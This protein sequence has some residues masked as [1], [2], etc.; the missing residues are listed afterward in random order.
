VPQYA[1]QG[2]Y[3]TADSKPATALL[4]RFSDAAKAN[5]YYAG[6]QA[7]MSACGDGGDLSVK[8]LWS[9]DTAAASVRR[10]AGDEAESYV[11]VSVVHGAT[12][13]LL[14]ASTAQPDTESGWAHDVVPA[15]EAV[16]D[17]A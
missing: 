4:L 12:V 7:R 11:E 13:A 14:A 16:V 10:Y 3:R 5:T 8:C 1:L 17:A 15:L 2:T 6:Y 9:E